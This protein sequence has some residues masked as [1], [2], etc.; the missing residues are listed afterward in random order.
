MQSS[1][2]LKK[3]DEYSVGEWVFEAGEPTGRVASVVMC[4]NIGYLL[5]V[6]KSPYTKEEEYTIYRGLNDALCSLSLT[7]NIPEQVMLEFSDIIIGGNNLSDNERKPLAGGGSNKPSLLVTTSKQPEPEPELE[8]V[9]G[10][11]FDFI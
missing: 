11:Y 7:R 9:S 4:G 10:P 8:M 2:E 5:V 3:V 1:K 6:S